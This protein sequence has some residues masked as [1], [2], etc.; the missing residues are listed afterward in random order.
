VDGGKAGAS[1]PVTGEEFSR[2]PGLLANISSDG[3]SVVSARLPGGLE[4]RLVKGVEG[5][6]FVFSSHAISGFAPTARTSPILF[7]AANAAGRPIT[8]WVV[9]GEVV[10]L[11][12][13]GI[14]PAEPTHIKLD[15]DGRIDT[16]LQGV[17]LFVAGRAAPLLYAD[18]EQINAII[19]FGEYGSQASMELVHN[20]RVVVSRTVGIENADP[21]ILG[22][23]WNAEGKPNSAE[24][25]ANPDEILACKI[26]GLGNLTPRPVDGDLPLAVLPRPVLPVAATA[27]IGDTKPLE[28]VYLG[29]APLAPAGVVQINF[30]APGALEMYE[31]AVPIQFT[32]ADRSASAT[33]YVR[34]SATP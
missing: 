7:G 13:V 32:A 21:A 10:S 2:G 1:F 30:R 11:Y 29:Q 19:P 5:R 20:D 26:S 31:S 24:N 18:S 34:A 9:P 14:G 3:A 23:C 28:V 17:R 4:G 12:G 22:S 27:S 33:I 6:A 15:A 16:N 25:P 8:E